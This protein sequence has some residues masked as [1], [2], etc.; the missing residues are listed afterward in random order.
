MQDVISWKDKLEQTIAET[1]EEIAQLTSHKERYLLFD[2]ND[3]SKLKMLSANL[4][5][6]ILTNINLRV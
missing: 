6:S 2:K 5:C 3:S 4:V 1:D